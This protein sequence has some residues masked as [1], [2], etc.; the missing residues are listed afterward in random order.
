ML[1]LEE[2]VE[3]HALRARG[4]LISA[5]AR[6]VGVDRKTVR[7]Y[8]S[9]Q[10]APGQ[11]VRTAP[12]LVEPFVAY[13][14][15]RLADDPHLWASTLLDELVELGYRGSYPSLTAAIRAHELRP[16]CEPCQTVRGRDVSIIAHPAGEET[17][18]D[19]VELPD[20]PPG[21]GGTAVASHG[22]GRQAHLL[23]G[24]LAHS[25]RWRGVLAEAEDFPHLVEALAGVVDRL[26]GVTRRWRFDRMATVCF[27]ASGK[28]TPAF[29]A[30]A[31]HY[32]VGIDIC[33]PRRGNRKGVVE[34]ANHA[35]AQRWWRTL[36]DVTVAA[37]QD[38]LDQ[39]CARLDRHGFVAVTALRPRSARSPPAR[40]C[41]RRRA[42]CSPPSSSS[43]AR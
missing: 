28:I 19:W 36:D 32:G 2:D 22:P 33:P 18:W 7:A 11:R 20:P 15:Q 27:P 4:W 43:P 31:R 41:A 24:A 40:V 3:V 21:W 23:V 5:I 30:V 16:H 25:G 35:A 6:H 1:S 37:A 34:K 26:D 12:T 13:C 14:R 10:R 38:G 42:R 39:L 9:G 29:A 8:L 17:Q